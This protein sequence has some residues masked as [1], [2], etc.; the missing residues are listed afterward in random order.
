MLVNGGTRMKVLDKALRTRL[1]RQGM[2]FLSYLMLL[3]PILYSVHQGWLHVGWGGLALIIVVGLAANGA[4][5]LLIRHRVGTGSTDPSFLAA[6]VAVASALT[7]AMAYFLDEQARSLTLVGLFTAF[8]FGV[9]RFNR[10]AYLVLSSVVVA[11]YVGMLALRYPVGERASENFQLALLNLIIL[12]IMLVWM[13]LLGSYVSGLRER[14]ARAHT[15]LKELASRD[16]LTGLYNRRHL[17]DTLDQQQERSKR[18][19]E[20]FALCIIDLDHF[21]D[22]NDLHGHNVGDEVL[23]GFAERMRA[24]LRKMDIIGRGNAD[25]TFGRYGG[26][27][28]L[29][30]LPYAAGSSPAICL[31]RLRT[32]I[33]AAPFVTSAGEIRLTFSAGFAQHRPGEDSAALIARADSALYHAKS[34][35]RDRSESGD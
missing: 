14:L 4:F 17:M 31:S 28:F 10:R 21:K 25:N 9:F 22:V 1:Q 15:R 29:L 24:Q 32:A 2:G 16:E 8:F 6:Q 35:G 23:R 20:P 3:L 12:V 34:A 11:G 33:D 13:S 26:E 19:G 18:Y 7:L 27:E 5:H 30:L